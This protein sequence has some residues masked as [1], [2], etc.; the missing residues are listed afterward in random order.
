MENKDKVILDLCG[1]TAAW[2]RPWK[3]AGFDV[4]VITLP[5]F[6]VRRWKEYPEIVQPIENGSVYGVLA[7][8]P[9]TRFSRACWNVPIKERNFREGMECVEAC[10]DIIWEI[11]K[12]GAPLKFWALEN[13]DGHLTKFLGYAPFS[14]QPWQFGETD[15]RATKRTMLW[16]YF[17]EPK[18]SVKERDYSVIPKVSPHSRPAGD[19]MVDASRV[20]KAWARAS[21]VERA[22]TSYHFAKAFYEANV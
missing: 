3:E 10:L 11:Q 14:F 20:N 5:D 9:C 2:S 21:A 1:G 8:P 16:G 7:A 13:P 22:E 18:K 17:K 6:D 19:G 12:N 15:F 4:R